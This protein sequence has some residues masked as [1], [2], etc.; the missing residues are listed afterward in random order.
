MVE[1][2]LT[3][4]LTDM[5]KSKIA[6]APPAP[7]APTCLGLLTVGPFGYVN[8]LLLMSMYLVFITLAYSRSK[9]MENKI[10]TDYIIR[11]QWRNYGTLQ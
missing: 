4:Q 1:I 3:D 2:E 11:L 8:F 9:R 6:M 5:P 7:L 10:N